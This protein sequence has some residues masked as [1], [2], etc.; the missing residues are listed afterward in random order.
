MRR[1]LLLLLVALLLGASATA[2][3]HKLARRRAS[4]PDNVDVLYVPPPGYLRPMALGYRESLADLLWVRALLFSGRHLGSGKAGAVVRYTEAIV[5]LSPRF[6]RAYRWGGV[7]AI[8]GGEAQISR[9]MVDDALTIYRQG[10]DEFPE[11]HA[12]LYATAMLLIYQLNSTPGYSAAE[13]D[14]ATA[15]GAELLRRAAAFGADPLVRQYAATLVTQHASDQ[16]ARQFLTSQLA[17]T[18]DEDYRRLLR[19]K[20]TELGGARSVK[21]VE[22][23]RAAFIAHHQRVAPYTPDGVFALILDAKAR[24]N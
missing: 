3:H 8:Y 10:L 19:K 7:T 2:V 15:E 1:P 6:K 5:G 18:S 23:I 11:D 4:F 9:T 20:L 14:A 21:E 22:A 13:R 16:L 24:P 12:L 17:Q